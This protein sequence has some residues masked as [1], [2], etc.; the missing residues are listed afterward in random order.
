MSMK[1]KNVTLIELIVVLA[2]ISAFSAMTMLSFSI[3]DKRR[4]KSEM[5]SILA[6]ISWTRE[7]ALSKH[8]NYTISFNTSTDTYTIT[9]SSGN[10]AKPSRK[11]SLVD[12]TT[13]PNTMTFSPPFGRVA[14]NPSGADNIILA[15]GS[16]T[17]NMEIFKDTGYVRLHIPGG[18]PGCFIAT[19][20]YSILPD[21]GREELN[22]LRIF[23]DKYLLTNKM[24]RFFVK[25]YYRFSPPVA[26]YISKRRW[27]A[28]TTVYAL[29]P[30]VWVCKKVERK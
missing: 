26:Y 24:G 19:A 4:I 15:L 11:L 30:I 1:K 13:A 20:A 7:M 5:N 6:D 12:I 28:K 23:R 21:K 3:I 8:E 10:Q 27:A 16:R 14:L 9:D 25:A 29:K 18:G 17:V 2:I 22:I